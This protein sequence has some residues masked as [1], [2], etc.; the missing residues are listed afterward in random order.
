MGYRAALCLLPSRKAKPESLMTARRKPICSYVIRQGRMSDSQRRAVRQ[1]W[2]QY[3]LEL[4]EGL[5]DLRAKFA[6]DQP[7]TIEIGFGMGDSLLEMATDDPTRNFIGIE[8]HKPGIGHLLH[9]ANERELANLK[10]YANDSVKVLDQCI[11]DA[12]VGCV[13]IFFPDP[14]PKR[15]H[16]KRRLV[17]GEFLDLILRSLQ[18]D[19]V[20]HIVTD[21]EPYAEEITTLLRGHEGFCFTDIPSRPKT[22]YELRGIK[23]GHK[24]T[25]VAVRKN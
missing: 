18:Q 22:K 17:R 10:I 2:G 14:W 9:G 21:W 11:P 15:R 23:L 6:K 24:V 25:D 8:V 16:H 7:V 3:G 20:L 1:L 12:S 13:Q 19:G 5:V 4:S